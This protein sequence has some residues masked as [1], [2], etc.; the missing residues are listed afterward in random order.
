LHSGLSVKSDS[1]A[2]QYL[3]NIAAL[4]LGF[5]VF[6][7][8]EYIPLFINGQLLTA[9]EPL[10]TIVAIQF[11]PLLAIVGVIA[12][13][14][15]RRTNSYLPGAIISALFVTWYIVAGQATQAAV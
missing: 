8:I 9:T 15:Y 5:L 11:L 2:K 12:T 4:S 3:T 10:N 13:F 6:L 14:T 1:S 7:A